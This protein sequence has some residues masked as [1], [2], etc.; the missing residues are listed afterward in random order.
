MH[1]STG[2]EG[3]RPPGLYADEPEGF[4]R[5]KMPVS[6]GYEGVRGSGLRADETLEKPGKSGIIEVQKTDFHIGWKQFGKKVGRHALDFGLN[7]ASENDR[8]R[9][10]EI[11]NDIRTNSEEQRIGE[12]RGQPEDVVFYIK[13]EDVVITKQNG[14]FVTIMKGGIA[15]GRVKNARKREI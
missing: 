13:G 5:G 10:F 4:G 2:R 8:S 11:I 12:W 1:S 9:L 6:M 7:P 14:E 15:N 3:D